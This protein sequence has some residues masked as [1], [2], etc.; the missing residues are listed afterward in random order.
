M[1]SA[2]FEHPI[3]NCHTNT[4]SD[5]GIEPLECLIFLRC[6]RSLVYSEHRKSHGTRT[7]ET[8][9]TTICIHLN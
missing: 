3:L 2:F 7:I 4:R 1:S 5:S 9:G 8:Q 6:V